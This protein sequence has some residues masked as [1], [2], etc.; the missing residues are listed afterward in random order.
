V[1]GDPEHHD[2]RLYDATDIPWIATVVD[3]VVDAR[4][5][6]WRILRERLEHSAIRAPRIAAILGALRRVLGGKAESARIARRVRA[7]VLGHPAL[8]GRHRAGRLEVASELLGLVPAE[9]DQLMWI[10]LASER[11]VIL[12]DGRPDERRL[13]AYANLDRIGRAVRRAR[14]LRLAVWGEA[15]DLVRTAKR[16]GLLVTAARRGDATVLH[17]VGPLALFHDTGAYGGALAGLVPLLADLARFELIVHCD[18]GYGP[19]TLRVVPPV[20]LPPVEPRGKPSLAVRLA[21]DLAK[22]A[23]ELVIERDPPP[24]LHGAEL[25]FPDLAID[26]GG[27]RTWLDVIGFA[28]EAY[29]AAQLARYAAAGAGVI[30]CVH[31]RR[32]DP[33]ADDDP[34][35]LRFRGRLAAAAVLGKLVEVR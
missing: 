7:L 33:P 17:V 25:S 23:P 14:E 26:H 10:D 9:V 13:A 1:I 16:H 11:P 2:L 22:A 27:R 5:E 35:L 24:I 32:G 6:P 12:P 28:T 19:S 4:G 15:H 8:D 20:L 31:D 18:L 29:A 3:H 21:K 34:R 30:L